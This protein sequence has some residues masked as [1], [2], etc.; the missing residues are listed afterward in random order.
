MVD[1]Q[2][3]SNWYVNRYIAP[4]QTVFTKFISII[5]QVL[6]GTRGSIDL[7]DTDAQVRLGACVSSNRNWHK[8]H[9]AFEPP[10]VTSI[11]WRI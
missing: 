2:S 9:T 5:T 3:N 7:E 1:I 4:L 8:R 6:Q 10:H 11:V